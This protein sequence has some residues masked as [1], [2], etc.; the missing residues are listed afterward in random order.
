MKKYLLLFFL[1]LFVAG[2]GE[3]KFEYQLSIA[4]K[5][6]EVASEYTIKDIISVNEGTIIN[7]DDKIN[8]DKVGTIEVEVIVENENGK[9]ETSNIKIE[10][11]DTEAPE[12]SNVKDLIVYENDAV[13][14]Y[15]DLVIED[16]ANG[17]I[18]KEI[19]GDYDLS[20]AGVY[21]LSYIIK[22]ASGNETVKDF[23]L[24]V[25]KKSTVTSI[26]SDYYIKVNKK[27]NVVM[28]YG[29]DENNEYTKLIKTFVAS[30]GNGTPIGTF[31]TAAK[32]E[33]LSLVGNVW[34][35]YTVQING[36]YWFHS[37]PYYSKAGADGNWDD[38][39]Y[40][41]YNKLGSLA[42]K[43]CIRLS[44]ID[45]K[46]IFD[47]IKKGTTV[48]IYESDSLPEGVTKPT[49]IKIDIN[50]IEKRGWDPT[51]P[52]PNNPYNN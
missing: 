28:V 24:T 47:N 43:G 49:P 34:G 40:E 12:V 42:S 17:E 2:C 9:R 18:S 26:A 30:A 35:H 33:T 3:P 4:E 13:D 20:K 46:W 52:N 8:T 45:A 16:N 27:L 51:D 44:T 5:S 11:K 36:P 38:L 21:K 29:K 39:E 15:K 48:E 37:V 7:G 6:I 25:K 32:Y 10:I 31:T 50:D 14:F 23:K 41:E 19:T 1:L 22:D